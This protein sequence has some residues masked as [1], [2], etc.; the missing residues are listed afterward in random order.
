MILD[1]GS[2]KQDMSAQIH[3]PGGVCVVVSGGLLSMVNGFIFKAQLTPNSACF[4][5]DPVK[6]TQNVQESGNTE[7][8]FW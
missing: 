2:N 5:F 3:G 4:S 1:S 7:S 8:T 6:T